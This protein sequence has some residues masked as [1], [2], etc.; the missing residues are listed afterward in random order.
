MGT[1]QRTGNP[2]RTDEYLAVIPGQFEKKIKFEVRG[3]E[4]CQQWEQFFDGMPDKNAPV[5]VKFE[6]DAREHEGRWFNS[7]QAWDVAITTW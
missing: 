2:W 6:I 4:G 5:L 1:S 7:I 3:V